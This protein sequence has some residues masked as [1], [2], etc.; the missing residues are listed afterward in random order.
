M[1]A[2][3]HCLMAAMD[4]IE[5]ADR[6]HCTCR[7]RRHIPPAG[8]D[9]H[10]RILWRLRSRIAAGCHHDFHALSLRYLSATK[11]FMRYRY[12]T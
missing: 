12:A 6:E 7:G 10:A 1:R 2:A 4:A 3:K 8:D 5:I 11:T 9:V